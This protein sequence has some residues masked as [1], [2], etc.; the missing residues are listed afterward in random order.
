MGTVDVNSNRK[1]TGKCQPIERGRT[2]IDAGLLLLDV[3]DGLGA[4]V[5][6]SFSFSF[7]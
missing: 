3:A 6:F 5:F 4:S 2:V 7:L 1:D